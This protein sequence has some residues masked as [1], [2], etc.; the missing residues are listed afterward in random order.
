MMENLLIC[1]CLQRT[2]AI[3]GGEAA[4]ETVP[5]A[6]SSTAPTATAEEKKDEEAKK[7]AK[8]VRVSDT[9]LLTE[10]DIAPRRSSSVVVYPLNSHN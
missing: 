6:E 7:E 2:P 10:P 1:V 5:A 4:A 3:A 8:K 9:P